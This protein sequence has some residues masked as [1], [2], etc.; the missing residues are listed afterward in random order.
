MKLR[1][2]LILIFL[3]IF[4]TGCSG[5]YNLNINE[6]MSVD[7]ELY[8]NIE[9]KENLY[10]K[11]LKI[12]EENNISKDKYTVSIKENNIEINYKDSFLSIEEYLL[13][14]KVYHNMFDEIQFNKSSDYID[15]Y[16][17]DKI[18]IKDNSTYL[19]GSNLTDFDVIQLNI[20]NPF[21][22]NFSN[23]EIVNDNIYTWTITKDDITKK[24]QMQFKPQL[25]IFPYREVIVGS[26][27]FICFAIILISIY[28]RYRKKQKV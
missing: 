14:S 17:N 22:V 26:V 18:K 10:Q 28:I 6:D 16:V 2:K 12:F 15:L 13:N 7:E 4:L 19:N 25:N 3:I 8:L 27:I 1:F 11:T 5:N 24:I 21:E 9:N 23:A 20:T